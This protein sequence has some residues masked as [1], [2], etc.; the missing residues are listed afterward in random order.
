TAQDF[1]NLILFGLTFSVAVI[2]FTEGARILPVADTALIGTL[3]VPF[4]ASAAWLL[5]TEV[6]PEATIIGGL[7]V[8]GAV[9]LQA[10]GDIAGARWI[11]WRS[12]RGRSTP[13]PPPDEVQF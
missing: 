3:D 11:A 9:S 4:A 13:T 1:Q 12:M 10:M 6:P 7:I 8:I 2:L 5:L